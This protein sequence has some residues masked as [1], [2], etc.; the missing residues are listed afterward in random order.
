LVVLRN[1][2]V[3]AVGYSLPE[4]LNKVEVAEDTARILLSVRC[5][6]PRD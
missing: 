4:A 5:L 6:K 3:V 1:H 2:G